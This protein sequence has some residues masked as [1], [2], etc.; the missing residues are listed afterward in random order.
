[1]PPSGPGWGAPPPQ[2]APGWAPGGPGPQQPG[3]SPP[4][5]AKGNGCLKACLI[6]AVIGIVLA[7]IAVIGLIF[8]ANKIAD[9]ALRQCPFVSDAQLAPVLGSDTHASELTGFFDATV[10]QA[11]DKR[12]LKDATDCWVSSGSSTSAGLGRIAQ[13]SGSDA[14]SRFQ[15]EHS[16]AA[17]SYLAQ[18]LSGVGDEAFCTGVG[19]TGSEGALVRKGDTLV[20]VSLVDTA[21]LSGAI[22]TANDQGVVYSSD[23]CQ[24]AAQIAQAVLK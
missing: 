8:F 22:P 19:T 6:V 5:P 24:L 16:N 18:D 20:Y 23:G 13:Y 1:V 4:P 9:S 10:G 14:S 12:V 21:F 17:G 3:W 15:S 11:L 7:I 2:Q